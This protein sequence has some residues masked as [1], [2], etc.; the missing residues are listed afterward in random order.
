MR[1]KNP[2]RISNISLWSNIAVYCFFLLIAGLVFT[3]GLFLWFSRDLPSPGKLVNAQQ[4]QSTRIFDK[5]GTLLYSVYNKDQGDRVYVTI[6]QIPKYLQEGT[7][8]VEDKNFYTNNGFSVTGYLRAVKNIVVSHSINGGG[9]TLTQQLVKNVLLQDTSQTLPR[10]IKELILAIEVDKKYSKNDILEMYM[11]DVSYGG[12]NIGVEAASEVYFGKK[13]KDLDLAQS[14]MLSGI[15]QAPTTYSPFNPERYYIARTNAVLTTMVNNGYITDKQAKAALI[16]VKN[17]TFS[18]EN[19]VGLKAPFFVEKIKQQLSQQFGEQRVESGGLQVT[20]TLDY[21]IQKK[22][23]AVLPDELDKIKNYHVGNAAA[24]VRDAK[25]GE[26][27]AYAGGKDYFGKPEPDGCK[28]GINCTFE[29]FVDLAST[30]RQPGSSLKP[31]TY[32]TGFEKGYTPA[33]LLMDTQTDFP[34]ND[35]TGKMYTP[36][37]YDGK[38]HGPIQVRFALGNSINIP[39]V[40]MLAKVGLKDVMK[41]AYDMGISNWQPTSANLA[42]VGLSLVLGGRETTLLDESTVYGTFADQG[43]RHDPVFILKVTDSKGNVL[44]QYKPTQGTPVLSPEISFLISH[45]L[46]DNNAR[47]PEFG[48]Y[49]SLVVS[50]KTVSVKTGTTDDKRDNWTMGYT[51][52]YVVGV[53]VGND[54]NEPMNQAISSGITGAAPIWNDIMSAVLKGKPDEQPQKPDDVMAVQIDAYGGGLPVDGKPTR[55]EYFIKGTQPTTKSPIY[56]KLKVQKG[57]HTKAASQDQ[58][59]HGDYDEM[60]FIVFHE[61][62]PVSTDGKNRWQDGID[63]WIKQ[64]YAADHPEY[65]PPGG[66]TADQ[67]R[68]NVSQTPTPTSTNGTE[69]GV[70]PTETPTPT[71]Q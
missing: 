51:P 28:P 5:N 38:F 49:S 46:L 4:G 27:L 8:S 14:A 48:L 34:L 31:V 41:N 30:N 50:G 62:D 10:K 13:V 29:P 21:N 19:S 32:A 58:I 70:T 15:P 47:Q 16:E 20:T 7:I 2:F 37:N 42:N 17:M 12:T 25:T 60:D 35:G 63:A 57:D 33:T 52:S 1:A 65:Y 26:I 55:S 66:V 3:V 18:H 59:N 54:D 44:Y 61:D 68:S 45:I 71:P 22:V 6:S 9:S 53:W 69:G 40:K 43:V 64:T 67:Q 24:I 56:Q 11:N 23:E 39:A 36:V